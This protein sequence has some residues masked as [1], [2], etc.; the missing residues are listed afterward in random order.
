MFSKEVDGHEVL[1]AE[2]ALEP[3]LVVAEGAG[4]GGAKD[5]VA[6]GHDSLAF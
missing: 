2:E 6:C 3:A 1:G 5:H 4:R